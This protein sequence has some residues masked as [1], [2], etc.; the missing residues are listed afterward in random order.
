LEPV[1]TEVAFHFNVPHKLP[2]VC[3]L[4]R[5]AVAAK[6]R[7]V[8]TGDADQL[9]ELDRL[10]WT[11][12]ALDFIPHCLETAQA[13]VVQASAVVLRTQLALDDNRPV[14]VNLGLQVP[15]G[16]ERYQRL[17]E[18]VT[19]LDDDRKLARQRW[20]HYASRGYPITRYNIA[21]QEAST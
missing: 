7:V 4:L 1:L 20:R 15:Q 16:F 10:I 13:D 8:V 6:A 18:L 17:I 2:Y 3:R 9:Q 5:K 12:S 21:T 19:P 14:L 11:F